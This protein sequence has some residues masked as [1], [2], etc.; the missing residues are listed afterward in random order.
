MEN[1]PKC[2]GEALACAEQG[3]RVLVYRSRGKFPVFAD[4]GSTASDDEDEITQRLLDH[5]ESNIGVLLGPYQESR[6]PGVIDI[7]FDSEEGRRTADELLAGVVTPT[8]QSLRSVHRLF[9]WDSDFPQIQKISTGFGGLE[10]RLGGGSKQTQSVLPPSVHPDD[11]TVVYRWLSGL[12]IREVELAPV[13]EQVKDLIIH[14]QLRMDWFSPN[15]AGGQ[16]IALANSGGVSEGNRNES[17]ARICGEIL[18]QVDTSNTAEVQRA[19]GEVRAINENFQPPLEDSE[20]RK[21]F[22]SILGRER[23]RQREDSTL[24]DT[25]PI[26]EPPAN[27]SAGDGGDAAPANRDT[28]GFRLV[29][30]LST[31]RRCRLIHPAFTFTSDGEP[32]VTMPLSDLNEFRLVQKLVLDRQIHR[33]PDRTRRRWGTIVQRLLDSAERVEP[34]PET[35]PDM[36]IGEI[37]TRSW[38]DGTTYDLQEVR[39]SGIPS[40]SGVA[41]IQKSDGVCVGVNLSK[42]LDYIKDTRAVEGITRDRVVS[43]LS[44]LGGQK[45]KSNKARWWEIDKRSVILVKSRL[46]D[47]RSSHAEDSAQ[48]GLG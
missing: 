28:A 47:L 15:Q 30:E 12:S 35:S 45:K 46:Y 7:E 29:I 38:P 11:R 16:A 34:D 41:N 20:V 27:G 14:D 10:I 23:Q 18:V 25:I 9:L 40:S 24:R 8:Y 26:R 36:I 44:Q 5:P 32:S 1:E 22:M 48:E 33:I 37:I 21:T 19:L 43:I 3:I 42:L 31:P 17:L 2:L 13:P 6:I 4:W 39:A